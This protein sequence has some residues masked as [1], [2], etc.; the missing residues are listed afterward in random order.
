MAKTSPKYELRFR[1][2]HFQLNII[3]RKTILW[4]SAIFFALV[5]A[6]LF[7]AKLIGFF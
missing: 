1:W 3:G 4:W 5:G 6:N 7:G 2:G